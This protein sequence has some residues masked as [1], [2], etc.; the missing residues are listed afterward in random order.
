MRESLNPGGVY[1]IELRHLSDLWFAGEERTTVNTWTMEGGGL[2][3]TVEWGARTEGN[4]VT[5][6]E[7]VLTRLTLVRGDGQEVLESWGDLRPLLPQELLALVELAGGWRL[8]G[9]WGEFEL[10]RRLGDDPR[11][12]RM[13]VALQR[14]ESSHTRS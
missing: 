9:W 1:V 7:R 8:G 12:W 10:A 2:K 5:Q 3:V 11:D 14:A 6:V 13:I 4:P